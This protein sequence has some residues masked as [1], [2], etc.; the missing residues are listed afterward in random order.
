MRGRATLGVAQPL[1]YTDFSICAPTP[2]TPPAGGH[3]RICDLLA[4]LADF[5]QI[6][7]R[8]GIAL[9][10]LIQRGVHR[11]ARPDQHRLAAEAVGRLL[12]PTRLAAA[13]K[14]A[15]S[16]ARATV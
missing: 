2:D 16:Q 5:V 10:R 8:D 13:M 3:C 9:D 12:A 7:R 15:F 1:S 14:T 6:H 4:R 11:A